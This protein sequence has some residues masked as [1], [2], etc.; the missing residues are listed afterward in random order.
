MFFGGPGLGIES[1]ILSRPAFTLY[2]LSIML[3]NVPLIGLTFGM[4]YANIFIQ[5]MGFP[6]ILMGAV[7]GEMV[8]NMPRFYASTLI[9]PFYLEFGI[10][11]VIIGCLVLG[12]LAEIPHKIY[13]FTKNSFFLALYCIQLSILLVWIETGVIQYYLAFL[14]FVIG[15]WCFYRVRKH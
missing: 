12:F 4:M 13:R 1:L 8:V 5:L 7:V 6:R 9:G 11:G 2:V 10:L 3:M 15:L 14:F